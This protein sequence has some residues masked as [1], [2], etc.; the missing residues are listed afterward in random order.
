MKIAYLDRFPAIGGNMLLG[1]LL[2]L[3]LDI[4]EPRSKA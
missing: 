4:A 1:V 3:G 2:D